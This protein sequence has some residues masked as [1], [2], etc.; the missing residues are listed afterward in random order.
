MIGLRKKELYINKDVSKTYSKENGLT[1]EDAKRHDY[2]IMH[3]LL[4]HKH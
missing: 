4:K 2:N 1:T 3:K